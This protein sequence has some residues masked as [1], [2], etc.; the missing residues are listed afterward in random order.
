MFDFYNGKKVV[1]TGAAGLIGSYVVKELAEHTD[2]YIQASVHKRE[3]NAFTRMANEVWHDT[4]LTIPL[5]AQ[6]TAEDAKVVIHCA[7][8]TGGVNYAKLNPM[9]L[10]TSNVLTTMNIIEACVKE[11][12]ERLG[13]LSSTTVY[14][15][16]D[17]PVKEEEI[18]TGEPA[19]QYFGIAWAKRYLEKFAR[20][21][22]LNTNLKIGII[23]P[24]AA[25]GRYDDFNET[26]G[27]FIPALIARASH[28]QKDEPLIIWGDGTERR[29]MLHAQ[30]V[31]RGLLLT[32]EKHPYSD[33]INIGKGETATVLE[34]AKMIL[35]ALGQ[36]NP[37]SFDTTKRRAIQYRAVDLT[38]AKEL[39][40]FKS[41][42]SIEN[43]IQDTVKFYKEN[44][45][46]FRS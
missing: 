15:P 14:P 36:N 19:E 33:P 44:Q 27:H 17:H 3:I 4:D 29:D 8:E 43:G 7:G 2:A 21:T 41:S 9:S 28:L 24:M 40:D 1:V 37:I 31:A 46:G 5:H 13:I 30:D 20:Y 10:I 34:I 42:V 25:Y 11:K 22:Q 26:T 35:S 12:V 16:Y 38:K 39:L 23:R 18:F 6:K 45:N 32:V